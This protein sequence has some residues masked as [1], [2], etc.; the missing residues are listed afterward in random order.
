MANRITDA[1]LRRNGTQLASPWADNSHLARIVW[2]ELYPGAAGAVA[3]RAE[4]MAVPAIARARHLLVTTVSP[5]P[6]RAYK[7]G[8]QLPDQPVWTYRADGIESPALRM[9]HTVDDLLFYGQSLWTAERDA[10]GALIRATHVPY[11]EWS[12]DH[13]GYITIREQRQPASRVIHIPGLHS[14]ICDFGA[15]AIRGAAATLTSAV[16]TARHPL[17]LELHDTGDYPLPIAEA[18]ELVA[19][20]RTAMNDAGGV[21]YTSPGIEAKMHPVSADTLLVE[22]R[23]SFAVDAARIVGIPSGMIDAY[24]RGATMTYST[25][26]DMLQHF[27]HLG[28]T[29]YTTPITARLSLDDCTPRGSEIRFD[30][31]R[32]GAEALTDNRADAEPTTPDPTP[33]PDPA[34]EV[35]E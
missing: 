26:A 25:L 10:E 8:E 19:A 21:V 35:P 16:D 1:L 30:I 17:R 32:L 15:D 9:A 34:P 12:T 27:L 5:L 7:Y 11:S 31:S 28:A 18:R 23:E 6:V 4:A 13:D 3:T 29:L 33:A 14:G 20:A 22:G 24:S 2:D